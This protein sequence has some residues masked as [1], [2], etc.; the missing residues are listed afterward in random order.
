MWRPDY[1]TPSQLRAYVRVED[2]V[3]DA[4]IGNA[5]AGASRA[6][7]RHCHR[8][9]GK[10]DAAVARYYTPEWSR[11]LGRWTVEVD[12]LHGTTGLEV[13]LDADESGDYA[14][15]ITDFS[16]KPV[17]AQADGMP[18]TS[19]V[20]L[21]SN[22]T[23]PS[24]STEDSI[25]VTSAQFGWSAVPSAVVLACKLQASRFLARREAPFGIAG[26]PADGSEMRLLSKVD[27]DVGV[28]LTGYVRWWGAR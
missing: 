27:P 2:D 3:D 7:D 13:A 10:P 17:N 18:W 15:P 28:S 20:L 14:T 9:F 25:E 11:R 16:M 24:S 6:I 21:R 1:I 4:E 8:Q 22:S 23:L 5:I 19:M 12:D 26:S